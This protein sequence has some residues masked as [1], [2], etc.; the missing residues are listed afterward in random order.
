MELNDNCYWIFY[1]RV[2]WD[3]RTWTRTDHQLLHLPVGR[4]V[5]RNV[6][7]TKVETLSPRE[8][9]WLYHNVCVLAA[10]FLPSK[11]STFLQRIII[12]C[13]RQEIFFHVV[14]PCELQASRFIHSLKLLE[15][16]LSHVTTNINKKINFSL[17][18]LKVKKFWSSILRM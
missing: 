13:N 15:I 17:S 11:R 14:F 5:R 1:P 6:R 7:V 16:F 9:C 18:G 2:W 4:L 12:L 10:V 8:P 3:D